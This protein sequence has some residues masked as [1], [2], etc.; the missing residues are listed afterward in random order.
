MGKK[1]AL[2]KDGTVKR[3]PGRKVARGVK[4]TGRLVLSMLPE[5]E[6]RIRAAAIAAGEEVSPWARRILLAQAPVVKQ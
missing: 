3:A 5:E 6:A 4:A 2:N 1:V